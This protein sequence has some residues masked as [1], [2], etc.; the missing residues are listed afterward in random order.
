VNALDEVPQSY[1]H[2]GNLELDQTRHITI[3]KKRK[4][5]DLKKIQG[6]F[7]VWIMMIIFFRYGSFLSLERIKP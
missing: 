4:L 6:I 7:V 1:S 5:Q 3:S 2:Q